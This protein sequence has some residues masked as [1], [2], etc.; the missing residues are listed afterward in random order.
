[1]LTSSNR[2]S[3]GVRISSMSIFS[4]RCRTNS[5][6]ITSL[7]FGSR[8]I[9]FSSLCAS[10]CLV[11]ICRSRA[12]LHLE[13]SC[14]SRPGS[15]RSAKSRDP[16]FVYSLNVCTLKYSS[17]R[18]P[19]GSQQV[20]CTARL[21]SFEQS[22]GCFLTRLSTS[23]LPSVLE[24]ESHLVRTWN[25]LSCRG[26]ASSASLTAAARSW[27]RS[28]SLMITIRVNSCS[29]Y[30]RAISSTFPTPGPD[31]MR[32]GRSTKS[33]STTSRPTNSTTIS[34]SQTGGV[35][36]SSSLLSSSLTLL[37]FP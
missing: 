20:R 37:P 34:V 32:P 18:T 12:G 23:F 36:S 3:V 30:R 4:S 13:I 14:A 6:Q 26:S 16:T 7:L 29:M 31:W 22:F 1:M 8:P 28:A 21:V 5:R 10:S 17:S 15:R 9:F 2:T 27:S 35:P 33:K 19:S 25:V 11:R 24:K